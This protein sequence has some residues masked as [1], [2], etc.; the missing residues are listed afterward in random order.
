MLLD[1]FQMYLVEWCIHTRTHTAIGC[2]GEVRI[3]Q[4]EDYDQWGI[5]IMVKFR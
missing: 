2:S 3:C 5:E 1:A 4:H